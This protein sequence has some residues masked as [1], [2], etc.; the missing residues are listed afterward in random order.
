MIM[1]K[2]I[3]LILILLFTSTPVFAWTVTG[4][5]G[6]GDAVDTEFIFNNSD[7]PDG[8]PMTTDGTDIAVTANISAVDVVA[9]GDVIAS[10]SLTTGRS[11][12]PTAIF[13]DLDCTDTDTNASIVGNCTATGSGA[14]ECDMDIGVQLVG[15]LTSVI[16]IDGSEGGTIGHTMLDGAATPV[17]PTRETNKFYFTKTL[18]DNAITALPVP[19]SMGMVEAW[20]SE[21][22]WIEAM[23]GSDGTPTVRNDGTDAQMIGDWEVQA[24]VGACTDTKV[25]LY[26]EATAT[27]T[28]DDFSDDGCTGSD[29]DDCD[30]TY[31][32]ITTTSDGGGA[33]TVLT[34]V[35]VSDAIDSAT[36]TTRGVGDAVD[37]TLSLDNLVAQGCTEC[38]D[39]GTVDVATL[40]S[41]PQIKMLIDAGAT[42]IIDMTYD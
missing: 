32:G 37:D 25:C 4:G 41:R 14:E 26:L 29:G 18:A 24:N 16:R 5:G 9:T 36:V 38:D 28:T 12:T 34:V 39:D 13:K 22:D 31:T 8:A 20:T 15:S 30:G 19:T 6:V 1:K 3:I 27:A 17:S 23:I 33:G 10:G 35:I 42:V 40:D 2:I 11:S 21:G 7:A